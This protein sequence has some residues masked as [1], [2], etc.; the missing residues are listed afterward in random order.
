MTI[1][2]A[3]SLESHAHMFHYMVNSQV[4]SCADGEVHICQ[5]GGKQIHVNSQSKTSLLSHM[6]TICSTM[7]TPQVSQSLSLSLTLSHMSL[8]FSPSIC[9][10]SLEWGRHT[11]V[12]FAPTAQQIKPTPSFS[13][14]FS[15]CLLLSSLFLF[16]FPFSVTHSFDLTLLVTLS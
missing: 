4:K 15:L 13:F 1:L 14:S 8:I 7:H 5:G 2:Y 12:H 10:G 3:S 16:H 9:T 11:L 6:N